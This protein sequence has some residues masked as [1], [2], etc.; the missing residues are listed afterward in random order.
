MDQA[1]SANQSFLRNFGERGQVTNLDR[2]LR[3]CSGRHRQK[4]IAVLCSPAEP[5]TC[6][7]KPLSSGESLR[8]AGRAYRYNGDDNL[9]D[10]F[11]TAAEPFPKFETMEM[12]APG[13]RVYS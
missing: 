12:R 13:R 2:G 8:V 3:L 6:N 5:I 7:D 10:S 11:F 4:A 9:G 1:A